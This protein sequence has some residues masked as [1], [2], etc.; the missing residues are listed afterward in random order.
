MHGLSRHAADVRNLSLIRKRV[1]M[2]VNA[3]AVLAGESVFDTELDEIDIVAHTAYV[4]V[5]HEV[6]PWIDL[7]SCTI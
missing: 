2:L 4:R 7:A 6:T 1:T 3:P 5:P